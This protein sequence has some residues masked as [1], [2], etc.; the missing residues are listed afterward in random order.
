MYDR[1]MPRISKLD[2]ED[3]LREA[4]RTSTTRGEVLTKMGL[5]P[6]GGNYHVLK[7]K[8]Q[9]FDIPLHYERDISHLTVTN[10][11]PDDEVF[12]EDSTY[13]Q[14]TGIKK[15]LIRDHG[16]EYKCVDCGLEGEWNGKPI[17]LTLEH[18]NGVRND[19]RLENLCFLCPN[20]HSQTET[21]AG[22][23]ISRAGR[24]CTECSTWLTSATKNCPKGCN[25]PVVGPAVAKVK[26]RK[27]PALDLR[28]SKRGVPKPEREKIVW[29]PTSEL[30]ALVE[31]HG[32]SKTGR[33]LGVS[34]NAIRKRIRTHPA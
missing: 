30:I 9:K 14:R 5:S 7:M 28:R 27:D 16:F 11:R 2:Q 31:S 32:Y 20:C 19:N 24:F 33:M 18:K 15:R 17:V 3:A 12:C 25:K 22:R 23:N 8:C 29:L 13:T 6:G 10:T 26:V 1:G 34:D 21:Y 4:V